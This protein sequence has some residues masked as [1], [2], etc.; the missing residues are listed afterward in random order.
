MTALSSSIEAVT[1]YRRGARVTRVAEVV[2]DGGYPDEVHLGGLPLTLDDGSVRVSVERV[3]EA[4]GA[5]PVAHRAQVGLEV[6]ETVAAERGPDDATI[7]AARL[8]ERQQAA[9]LKQRQVELSR[10]EGLDA[11]PRRPPRRDEAPPPPP[12]AARL[13]LLGWREGEARRLMKATAQAS[14]ALREA[15]ERRQQLEARRDRA[16]ARRRDQTRG[17]CK[18]VRVGLTG[19]EAGSVRLVLE[20]HVPGARWAPSYVLRIASDLRAVGLSLRAQVAQATGEDWS[21]VSLSLSTA[22][23]QRFTELPELPGVRI[24]RAQPAPPKVGWRPPPTGAEA[25]YADYDRAVASFPPLPASGPAPLPVGDGLSR[26]TPRADLPD[27]YDED[28]DDDGDDGY[29][30]FVEEPEENLALPV[31]DLP[32]RERRDGDYSGATPPAAPMPPPQAAPRR[33]GGLFGAIGGLAEGAADALKDAFGDDA[34]AAKVSMPAYRSAPAPRGG[35]G[36]DRKAKKSRSKRRPEPPEDVPLL[37][38][39]S[40]RVTGPDAGDRGRLNPADRTARYLELL[41]LQTVQVNVSVHQVAAL[42]QSNEAAARTCESVSLPERH[43]E[44]G[45]SEGFDYAWR[46]DH[47]AELPSDGQWHG[48]PLSACEV[49]STPRYVV[50]PRES[51][52]VFRTVQ[53]SNPLDAPLLAGPADIYIDDVYLMTTD[54]ATCA[55]RGRVSLGLGVEQSVKCARNTRFEEETAGLIRGTLSLKHAV[56]IELMSHLDAAAEIEVR[57]RIPVAREGDDD[58][59]VDVGKVT[60][61]WSP[62]EP[63]DRAPIEGAH[64]WVVTLEPGQQRTLSLKYTVRIPS[65]HELVGGNRRER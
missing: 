45:S 32:S 18:V 15:R 57:E 1:V 22:S 4:A 21:G 49:G 46:A 38:Y 2:W 11:V 33:S 62:H 47:P 43:R 44:P 14:E 35:G 27:E 8:E 48:L 3:G 39:G 24:G 10:L 12:T 51:R 5:P 28:E 25:L 23:P 16:A 9:A 63:D 42:I 52:E 55:P 36:E 65:K 64:R 29:G 50:V 20:Y 58:V 60:E 61:G 31:M 59:R 54:L 19:G 41:A 56:D 26:P 6:G 7:E 13:A 30:G 53:L 37:E 40:L 17:L 34:L